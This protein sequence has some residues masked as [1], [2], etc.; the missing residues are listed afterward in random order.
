MA[1]AAAGARQMLAASWGWS[2]DLL[3]NLPRQ[4]SK[5]SKQL[6]REPAVGCAKYLSPTGHRVDRVV[7]QLGL[8]PHKRVD[9]LQGR[10]GQV[11]EARVKRDSGQGWG[12]AGQEKGARGEALGRAQEQSG[13][14]RGPAGPA[15]EQ[16]EIR[17]QQPCNSCTL[18][19]PAA[20]APQPGRWLAGRAGVAWLV[21]APGPPTASLPQGVWTPAGAG[22][23]PPCRLR[24]RGRSRCRC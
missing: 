20:G 2:L 5:Q 22:A 8:H 13:D 9:G 18:Q 21:C 17:W 6:R 7:H 15:A 4:R 11:G 3:F 24:P 16:R 1:G 23:A 12:R 14:Y 10:A 19:L